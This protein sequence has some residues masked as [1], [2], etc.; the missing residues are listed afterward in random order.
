MERIKEIIAENRRIAGALLPVLQRIQEIY[1]WLPPA[2]LE[3]VAEGL[4]IPP[5]EVVGTVSF[6]SFL[7]T[8]KPGT[9]IIR[10]CKSA[11]CH[12][13]GTAATIEALE[14]CLGIK[15]GDTT[16]DGKFTLRACECLGICDRAPAVMVNEEVFGPV[17]AGDVADLLS[18][19]E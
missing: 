18:K 16:S 10:V 15:V 9:Y 11:P 19:F 17:R 13:Q 2:A 1:G 6:Y 7:N 12:I 5:A 14:K 8:E 3:A 4:D